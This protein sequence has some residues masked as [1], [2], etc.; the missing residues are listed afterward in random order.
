[1]AQLTLDNPT[2]LLHYQLR[3]ALTMENDSLAALGELEKAAASS[4][5]KKMF[6]HHAD[7]TREQLDNLASVFKLLEFKET[8]APSP[9]T[10]G[11]SKQAA[12]LIVKTAKPLL[13]QV[14]LSCALGNEH[15][16]IS[17]YQSLL[18]PVRAMGAT[19]VEALLVANLDQETHTSEELHEMLQKVAG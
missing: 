1:M 16:E 13:D 9:S 4:E 10:K 14:V 8:T 18:V 12:G 5:V 19:E 3:T 6:R 17:A 2:D 11:I 7:E 15:Y